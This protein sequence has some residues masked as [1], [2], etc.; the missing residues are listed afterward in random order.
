[1]A[2]GLGLLAAP[3][4]AAD[5]GTTGE[6]VT[7]PRV[8]V[9][10]PDLPEQGRDGL[11]V[12]R[13]RI[14]KSEQD[15]RDVPQSISIVTE[16]LIDDRNLDTLKQ[17]LTQTAGITFLA[18]E[19]GE[20]DIRLRGFSLQATGDIF[21]DGMRD[22]AFYDRD[23]FNWDRLELLRG[24][25]SMLFGRGSTGGAANQV[26]KQAYLMDGSQ[27]DLT[28]GS[29]AYR[30]IVGDVNV[31]TG[32]DAALRL[33]AMATTADS[34]GA[35]N[36]LDKRGLAGNFRW[37]I[38]HKDEFGVSLYRLEN[39]NGMNY[40]LPWISPSATSA[41]TERTMISTLDPNAY[42]GMASDRNHGT[43][44]TATFDHRHRFDANTALKTS[45]RRGVYTRDQRASTVRLC[46]QTTNATTG[47]VT[48]P[49]CP[50]VVPT[51]D[52]FSDATVFT[53]GTQLK[54]QDLDTLHAQSDFTTRFEAL[55]L[56]HEW[57]SGIDLA[58]EEKVVYAASTPA[59]I[60]LSKPRTTAGTPDDG[61]WIDE[62]ARV[63]RRASGFVNH[64]IGVYAQDL[65]TVADGWKLLAG[66][67]HDRMKGDHEQI[68]AT[69]VVTRYQQAI[70]EFS[71]RLGAI[72]QPSA[73]HSLHA[74]WGSSFNTSGDS[75]SYNA[76]SANTAP[77]QS[78]NTEIGARIDSEDRMFT[79]R[80]ALF[81]SVKLNERNT[82]PDT[83]AT[84]LLLSGKRHAAGLDMDINGRLTKDWDVYLSYMW[85]PDAKV[86]VAAPT[87]T[88]FGN[89]AGDRPGLTP[90][91]S[92][93]VWSSW[94]LTRDW[95][96]GTGVN[97]RSK[98]TPADQQ[99]ASAITSPGYGTLE[100]MTEVA[101]EPDTFI[102]KANLANVTNKLYGASLYRGHVVPGAGRTLQ[103][104]GTVKF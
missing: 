36:R 104:T 89:R 39:R 102:V 63:L 100:L 97:F 22:P 62:D 38:G 18:A 35:G 41:A 17:A 60:D 44:T 10:A 91:H 79:T 5:D 84:A 80:I 33:N 69:G 2:C 93:A 55:G 25:A 82:D 11:Q 19:G 40:G 88:T 85:I 9:T 29:H 68:A 47:V 64:N 61:A 31:V 8:T 56:T 94:Q 71:Q 87:A 26:T 58:R 46:Q 49:G 73:R 52:T 75:Y 101:I 21:I 6:A 72:W 96:V 45:V 3:A 28:L 51:L 16:R 32:E 23:A 54:I 83:A 66:L 90:K 95:R 34:D 67:R 59:G 50:T 13:T 1:M 57:V 76:L 24:S 12:K 4:W 42:Y 81:R 37:G 98:S 20:E 103:V 30:R 65:V 43:A 86:D 99:A 27:V 70:G 53:R 15:L 77:E 7:L 14:G 48:N 92:G 78:I 74:S